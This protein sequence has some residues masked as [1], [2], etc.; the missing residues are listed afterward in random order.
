MND[1]TGIRD[2]AVERLQQL[3][4]IDTTNPPGDEAAAIEYLAGVL[5][6]EGFEPV[7]VEEVPVRPSLVARLTGRGE[8][9]PLLL[10]GH[11][12]VVPAD[13]AEWSRP[14]FAGD[15]ADG[16]VWG[17]GALDMKGAVIMQLTAL[18]LAKR[19][20]LRM[21]GDVIFCALP[22]EE[23]GGFEGADFLVREH[24]E[25]VRSEVA[26]GEV[27]GYTMFVGGRRFYPIQVAEKVG[28]RV[29]I[30]VRGASGHGSQPIRDGAMAKA[31]EVLARLTRRRLPAHLSPVTE[32]FIRALGEAEP[33]LLGL[34]DP[35][36][37]DGV[38]A[39]LGPQARMY[40]A[41]LH[42]TA[43]PTVIQ[44]GAKSNVIPGAVTITV[45][46]R[47]LPG[48]R[49]E[50]FL[51]ELRAVVGDNA[52]IE[53]RHTPSDTEA[54]VDDFFRMLAETIEELDP[55]ATAVPALV[56]GVTDAR[57]FAR[58]G[59][60]TYGF[61]PV[62][63]TPDMPFWELFHGADERIPVDGLLF[64]IQALSRVL[65]RY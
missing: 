32:R 1:W 63:L 19:A 44:G 62:K 22:G 45:D 2:E 6:D 21:A 25:L 51:A 24:P 28:C 8:R 7:V 17:R 12:D 60:P 58:L 55:G 41:L 40:E 5:R 18:V 47:L 48:Q 46:G 65:E 29:D 20:G 34:L 42:N 14:P 57:H 13:P 33:A 38:L 49:V 23:T 27:G 35:A 3:L 50:E 39:E 31:G 15:V 61:A 64:G 11:V 59:T 37:I 56:S 54:P 4:R 30:T 10:Q 52:E 36:R 16:C 43:V 26:L 9:G 53:H